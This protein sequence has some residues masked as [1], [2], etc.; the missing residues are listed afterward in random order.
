MSRHFALAFVFVLLAIGFQASPNFKEI[1]AGVA[2]FLFGMVS[3]EEGFKAFTGGTLERLLQR[4]TDRLWKSVAFGAVATT[5]M[6]SSTLVSII[7]ISFLSAGM[8]GLAQGIGIIF[9]ANLGTTTG[10][11]LIAGFG[12][13]V[14]IAAYALPMLTFG[15]ILLFNKGRTLK[16]LGYLLTG[17][18]FLFLGIHFIKD[19][20]DAFSEHINLADYAVPGVAGLLLFT[21]IGIVIT[22]IMQSS[23][24][25]LLV[26]IAALGAGQITY[27]NAL[28]LSIGANVGTTLTAL[29]S[30]IGANIE[31]RRLAAA[32]L[33]FNVVTAALALVF[34]GRFVAAVETG[35]AWLGIDADDHTLKLALF[36]TLFNL[37]GLA[38]MLP[39][40]GRLVRLLETWLQPAPRT[41][42][43]P[44]YISAAMLE[45]PGA[46]LEAGRKELQHLFA[47]TFDIMALVLHADP[48]QLRKGE[49]L[50]LLANAPERVHAIDV[51]DYYQRRVKPLHGQILDFLARLETK[52][53]QARQAFALRA[54]S[55]HLLE[56]LKDLKHLQKNMARHLASP[57]PYLRKEYVLI[58]QHLALLLHELHKLS[59]DPESV[60][61]L[62]FDVLS[63]AAEE[64]DIVANGQLDRLI[65]EK[66]IGVETA[67]SLMNDSAY[68][69]DIASNLIA[70]AKVIFVPFEPVQHELE[71]ALHL[72]KDEIKAV[73]AAPPAAEQAAHDEATHETR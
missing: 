38:L 23:H 8:L 30:A 43:T 12:L 36:H 60:T 39:L 50:E 46:A 72:D 48:V 73:L 17:L 63:A 37:T 64:H 70:M 68:A 10:A 11:W 44:K 57:N 1:A 19:G 34:I 42:S 16:G 7:T 54:A 13:K 40:T 9:G 32:H 2:I 18:G 21:L 29:V 6:Q 58:R 15:V 45:M 65:R 56:A 61:P 27:E 69:Y 31:G 3:L 49:R 71:H 47:N 25:S 24:A 52:G 59:Q 67:T 35:S 26:I 33:A 20:F 55:Q 53:P 14:D 51:D 41:I 28:A 5:V 66:R 4:T 62:R 22:V